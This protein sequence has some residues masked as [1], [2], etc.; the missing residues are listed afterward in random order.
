MIRE[1][2]LLLGL[3]EGEVFYADLE[4]FTI[5]GYLQKSRGAACF[6]VDWLRL[7]SHDGYGK[8]LRVCVSVKKR[9]QIYHYK[10]AAFELVKVR[11]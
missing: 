9:L 1:H 6:A 4:R 11:R 10:S 7:R 8:E 5:I 2:N 3:A